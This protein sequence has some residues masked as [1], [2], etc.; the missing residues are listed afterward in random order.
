MNNVFTETFFDHAWSIQASL[1]IALLEVMVCVRHRPSGGIPF[2]SKLDYE[3]FT[4][5]EMTISQ[6]AW[7][8]FI[9]KSW[10]IPIFLNKPNYV[11]LINKT[12]SHKIWIIL[13]Q[14]VC[15]ST[16]FNQNY[17]VTTIMWSLATILIGFNWGPLG[18]R[19]MPERFSVMWAAF[20]NFYPEP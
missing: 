17:F 10:S 18:E 20:S 14:Y 9:C 6:N 13:S 2:L 3:D 19:I 4:L 7:T 8:S 1:I 16:S 15:Q 12:N 5:I 11:A